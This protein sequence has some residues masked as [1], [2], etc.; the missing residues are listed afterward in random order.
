MCHLLRSYL[1]SHLCTQGP[2]HIPY[3]RWGSSHNNVFLQALEKGTAHFLDVSVRVYLEEISICISRLSKV[4]TDS[5]P[6]LW[7]KIPH[8][9][10]ALWG[11]KR[12]EKKKKKTKK[13]TTKTTTTTTKQKRKEKKG[14]QNKV[15]GAWE[16]N[17]VTR[18]LAPSPPPICYGNLGKFFPI[19]RLQ[20]SEVIA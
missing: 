13:N 14:H 10:A 16:R 17:L 9:A 1:N 20:Q 18:V 7:T 12:K 2:K 8:Q 5:L 3:P 11:Q 6:D 19:P 15:K 4:V